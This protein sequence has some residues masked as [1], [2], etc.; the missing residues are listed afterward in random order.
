MR[1]I[2]DERRIIVYVWHE[3]YSTV[4]TTDKDSSK[5]RGSQVT[6]NLS[7]PVSRAV[8][9]ENV[10]RFKSYISDDTDT[11]IFLGLAWVIVI[12]T[13]FDLNNSTNTKTVFYDKIVVKMTTVR[14]I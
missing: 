8:V 6:M 5:Q 13:L 12:T 10:G 4:T 11:V 7:V 2:A 14:L 9:W 3:L 1:I